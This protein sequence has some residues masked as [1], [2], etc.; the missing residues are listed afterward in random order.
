[1]NATA[2]MQPD[3]FVYFPGNYRWSAGMLGAL[4]SAPYGGPDIAEVDRV[5][6]KLRGS[7][8]DDEAWFQAW[9]NEGDILRARADTAQAR[10]HSL[11]AAS[12]YLRAC[13]HYQMSD[14]FR[15]PKDDH[16]MA[17]YRESIV[18]FKQFA[19]LTDRPR[20]EVVELPS[21]DGP[22]P[23][24]FVHAENSTAARN[25]C[26]VR[27]GGFDTQKELQYL[28]GTPDLVRRGIS[29]L[30]V[31]GPGQG[32]A[33]RF[34]GMHLRPDFEIA[35]SAAIDYL[36]TRSDV[37]TNRIGIVAMSLGGYYAPR[38]VAMDKR[39]NAC[40]AW[41]ATWDFHQTWVRRIESLKQAALA[42]PAEHLLWVCGVRT[43]DEALKKL[44]GFRL[45]GIAQKV[46]CPF[47][48]MH[49]AQ[50]AQVSN[51]D[52][53]KMFDAIGSRDKTMRVFTAD[54][55]GAQHCQRDYL[56]PACEVL[57]DWLEEKFR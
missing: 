23:A 32:E 14:H 40:V 54:E 43:Y 13:L 22:F 55:G 7:Q 17:V 42:V 5:G 46:E 56:P 3:H 1:M 19:A 47:L 53:Q 8:G 18:C 49:G 24:Y 51:E 9:R 25:P 36:E 28:R 26:V 4:S 21:R 57:A 31:D 35:G 16:A 39:Y 34:R 44:E 15:Q 38:C 33:I 45:D 2:V 27:F 12:N 30:L 37:D 20:I 6:R 52:A 48:L 29:C 11:T 41:G 10:R 50:D